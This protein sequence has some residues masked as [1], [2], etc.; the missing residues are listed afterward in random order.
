MEPAST[1][2]VRSI[3]KR[4]IWGPRRGQW[5]LGVSNTLHA[6]HTAV[7]G[8]T[9]TARLLSLQDLSQQ[10][11]FGE[12]VICASFVCLTRGRGADTTLQNGLTF[13]EVIFARRY[14][15]PIAYTGYCI[16][17]YMPSRSETGKRHEAA[18]AWEGDSSEVIRGFPEEVR[19]Q[20]G[21]DLQLLQRG[22]QP[23]SYRPMQSV[24][25]G[26]YEL[27]QQDERSWYRVIYLSRI[28]D[29]IHVLHCF[30][31]DTKKTPKRDIDTAKTRLKRVHQ[32]VVEKRKQE[33]KGNKK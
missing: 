11:G 19:S 12:I 3:G 5:H 1:T 14:S 13:Q 22:E 9:G 18:I 2:R 30:E 7:F 8:K 24:G 16:M 27:R 15:C 26:V 31:K 33:K 6:T 28:D 29:V 32:R 23:S 20:L 25:Q 21:I 4:P 10:A 17:F